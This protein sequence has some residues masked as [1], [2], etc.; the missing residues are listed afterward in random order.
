MILVLFENP[1]QPILPIYHV[2]AKAEL[3]RRGECSS[4]HVPG[5]TPGLQPIT[6]PSRARA[7]MRRRARPWRRSR[8]RR[9]RRRRCRSRTRC[10]CG[11]RYRCN[12][13]TRSRCGS[14]GRGESWRCTGCWCRT[15]RAHTKHVNKTS[16]RLLVPLVGCLY[17]GDK[18]ATFVLVG[19][20][21]TASWKLDCAGKNVQCFAEQESI[22]R[23]QLHPN[24]TEN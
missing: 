1:S 13:R 18:E 3:A 12:G 20:Y 17:P 21:G 7:R 9:N 23:Q 24:S 10:C 8:P 5:S 14:H 15:G 19:D 22:R 2:A 16:D 11:S 4:V 6:I